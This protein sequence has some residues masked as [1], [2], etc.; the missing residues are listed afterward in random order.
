MSRRRLPP[1]TAANHRSDAGEQSGGRR[2]ETG[3]GQTAAP[4]ARASPTPAWDGTR[5][6][7]CSANWPTPSSLEEPEAEPSLTL[8]RAPWCKLFGDYRNEADLIAAHR[9][10]SKSGRRKRST[11]ESASHRCRWNQR[12]DAGLR[13][14]D[15]AQVSLRTEAHRQGDGR[16]KSERRRRLEV[17]GRLHRLSRRGT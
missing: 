6:P 16:L 9:E 3:A 2:A 4:T 1:E 13:P 5:Q 14:R 15:P 12:K 8:S 7:D 17:R 10:A 11:H